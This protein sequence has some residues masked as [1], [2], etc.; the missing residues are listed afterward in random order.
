MFLDLTQIGL[1][2]TW[3]QLMNVFE[4]N[5]YSE[6]YIN[7]PL[8]LFLIRS[9]QLRKTKH[10]NTAKV[11]VVFT[12]FLSCLDYKYRVRPNYKNLLRESTGLVRYTNQKLY[13]NLKIN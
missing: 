4:K 7:N 9:I 11:T 6:N 8:K 13:S 12:T 5:S 1:S 10:T 3:N 2:Y